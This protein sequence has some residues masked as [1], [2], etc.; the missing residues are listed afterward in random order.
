MSDSGLS[1]FDD[2]EPDTNGDAAGR[3]EPT[4]AATSEAQDDTSGDVD[5]EATQ[6]IPTLPKDAAPVPDPEPTLEAE[7][8]QQDPEPTRSAA[9]V[10]PA[11]PAKQSFRPV[12]AP[13]TLPPAASSA[14]SFP[15]VRRGGYDKAAVDA[16]VQQLAGEKAGLSSSLTEAEKRV[17]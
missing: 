14:V 11:A 16:G 5:T 12:P 2:D 8:L 4:D 7:P 1:I 10:P 13:R 9:V 3:R 15:V 17:M 6:V